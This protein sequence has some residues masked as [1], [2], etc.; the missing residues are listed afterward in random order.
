FF[1]VAG[2]QTTPNVVAPKDFSHTTTLVVD[3][4]AGHQQHSREVEPEARP[5]D[6]VRRFDDGGVYLV[7]IGNGRKG[8]VPKKPVLAVPAAATVGKRW[9]WSMATTDRSD[10]ARSSYEIRGAE[11]LRIS[12]VDVR[13][14]VIQWV[15]RLTGS[16]SA[17]ITR[18]I[19]YSSE[20][21]L[22]VK[23][24]SVTDSTTPAV[25]HA[26]TTSTLQSLAPS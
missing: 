4:P 23:V 17:T 22:D 25:L 10:H 11:T 9:S 15:L 3:R 21:H 2:T 26:D 5:I 8:F 20:Y 1:S 7:R 24:H 6:T 19:W 13:C 16:I 18:T 14:A 12:G